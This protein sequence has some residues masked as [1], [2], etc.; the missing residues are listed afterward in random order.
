[1]TKTYSEL[2]QYSTF[3]DRFNYLKMDGGHVGHA[4]FGYDRYINQGFY[5]SYEWK[6]TRRDVIIRDQGCDLGIP[7]LDI[8]GELLVHHMNTM[9]L[10]DII[11]HEQWI[12]DPEFLI[13]TTKKTHN[14]LHFGNSKML[15]EVV[16]SRVPND[17]KLWR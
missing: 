3:E 11:H 8:H 15:P 9:T 10:D 1:M 12:L 16:M 14:A 17:T 4:T 7:G 13:T 2:V 5:M 6:Q